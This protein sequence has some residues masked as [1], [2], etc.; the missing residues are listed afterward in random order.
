MFDCALELIDDTPPDHA[1][2]LLWT[3]WFLTTIF[4]VRF[5]VDGILQRIARGAH[6]AVM[7]GFA[8]A[9]STF[10]PTSQVQGVFQAMCKIGHLPFLQICNRTMC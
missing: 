7:V 5:G 6:L 2:R 4:D 3:T 8:E 10:D 9:G 1:N